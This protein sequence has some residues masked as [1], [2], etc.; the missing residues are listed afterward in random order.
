MVRLFLI[1]FFLLSYCISYVLAQKVEKVG[2]LVLA[3]GGNPNWQKA[4]EEAVEPLR[5]KYTIS[6]AFGMA[7]PSTIEAGL[8]ELEIQSVKKVVVVPLFVSSHSP[9]IR[10]TEFLLGFRKELADEPLPVHNHGS[11]INHHEHNRFLHQSEDTKQ[12][13]NHNKMVQL[14]PLKVNQKIIIAKA[15]DEHPLVAEILSERVLELSREPDNETIVLVAHGPNDESDNKGWIKCMEN[16]SD[17]MR[18]LFAGKG[19]RFKQIFCLTIRD[20]APSEIYEQAKE[21]LRNIVRQAGKDGEVIVVPLLLAPGGVEKGIVSRLEGLQYKWSGKTL[22]P[23][24]NITKFIE[25]SVATALVG[26]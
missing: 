11:V 22:L 16:L 7:D 5:N 9:I 23:H 8:K 6:I 4:V 24:P 25:E 20:D 21:H 10:Q 17:Q 18:A 14:T 13:Y 19:R 26:R 2:V 12:E 1:T 3:H 15:L